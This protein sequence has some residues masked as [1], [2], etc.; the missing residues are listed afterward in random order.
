MPRRIRKTSGTDINL[1]SAVFHHAVQEDHSN[2]TMLLRYL[3]AT[4]G[5]VQAFNGQQMYVP[6]S[7]GMMLLQSFNT[8]K[9]RHDWKSSMLGWLGG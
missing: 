8:V 4:L 3:L 2:P 6:G 1:Y 9:S 7:L 5:R